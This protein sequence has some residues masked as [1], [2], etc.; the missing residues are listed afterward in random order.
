MPDVSFADLRCH[1]QTGQ[2]YVVS[3]TGRN[4]IYGYRN[5]VMCQLGDIERSEW[6]EM[7]K[8][9]IRRSGEQKLYEQLLLHLKDTTT[10][11]NPSQNWNSRHWSCTLTESLTMNSGWISWYLIK[12]I[13]LKSFLPPDSF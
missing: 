13:A 3:G 9:M 12:N 1:F 10:P 11:R 7:V 8:D 2:S 6:I 5:G 4:R